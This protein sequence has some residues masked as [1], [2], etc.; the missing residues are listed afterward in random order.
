M[1]RAFLPQS[2]PS[3]CSGWS[4]TLSCGNKFWPGSGKVQGESLVSHETETPCLLG[5]SCVCDPSLNPTANPSWG[6]Y[7]LVRHFLVCS[8][9]DGLILKRTETLKPSASHTDSEGYLLSLDKIHRSVTKPCR[10]WDEAG[11]HC[12][13]HIKLFTKEQS[14]RI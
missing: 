3:K 6:L 10:P 14:H 7:G 13:H 5:Q 12:C 4:S 2:I 9:S 11:L 8:C 1:Y